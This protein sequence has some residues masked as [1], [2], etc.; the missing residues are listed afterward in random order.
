MPPKLKRLPDEVFESYANLRTQ[1]GLNQTK[2][3]KALIERYPE[4]FEGL[5]PKSAVVRVTNQAGEYGLELPKGHVGGV[6]LP[7]PD[8]RWLEQTPELVIPY[9]DS[10]LIMS[11]VH[12]GSHSNEAV[13]KALA[14]IRHKQIKTVVW[15]GDLLDNAYKGHHGLRTKWAQ[16]YQEGCEAAQAVVQAVADCDS[17]THMVFLCGNHDDKAFRTTDREHEFDAHLKL[18]VLDHVTIRATTRI[19][20]T[21]RYYAIMGP[22]CPKPW[23][24]DGPENFPSIFTHQ[25][26]YGRN[27]LGVA[28]RLVDTEFA[29][30]YCGHQHHLAV[31]KHPS[32]M[33]YT[34]D[35]GTLQDSD[36]PAYKN[37]RQSTHPK[38]S[39]GFVTILHGTPEIWAMSYSPEWWE[40]RLN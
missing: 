1:G 17:V 16:P 13:E 7:K 3:G 21:N 30:T 20:I 40:S 31:G 32:G 39:T 19:D 28:K 12:A 36:L 27:Q 10:V 35:C 5:T 22:Q 38:W 29:N 25:Q 24:W 8:D 9:S 11:D 18:D 23:P 33:V 37:A 26:E 34:V 15:N 6:F 14:V 2:I 4:H